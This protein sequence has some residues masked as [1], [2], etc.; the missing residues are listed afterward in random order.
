MSLAYGLDITYK[1]ANCV[2][3]SQRESWKDGLSAKGQT[4]HPGHPDY[5]FPQGSGVDV[6]RKNCPQAYSIDGITH[7]SSYN[8]WQETA[9]VEG[10]RIRCDPGTVLI[11][12]GCNAVTGTASINKIGP[13][14]CNDPETFCVSGSCT[15]TDA[16]RNSG[17]VGMGAYGWKGAGGNH[18]E[19]DRLWSQGGWKRF[20][21][22]LRSVR[23]D[24]R[25][26]T[27]NPN[28][29]GWEQYKKLCGLEQWRCRG[30][31][32]GE[33]VAVCTST[34]GFQKLEHWVP[35]RMF[36]G[37]DKF[38]CRPGWKVT[39]GGTATGS[40]YHW[41]PDEVSK[42]PN[43]PTYQWFR[44]NGLNAPSGHNYQICA[45]YELQ[46]TLV[47]HFSDFFSAVLSVVLSSF[48][49]LYN[50]F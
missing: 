17:T 48:N 22:A 34:P 11:G 40:G 19:Y 21:G 28:W 12:G 8:Q 30:G 31:E 1:I 42:D 3:P 41:W 16:Q 33:A 36:M 35:S 32:G 39:S 44:N 38:Q 6:A 2:K 9:D 50:R 47:Y 29:E 25:Y 14:G 37:T 5:L 24:K 10:P 7:S 18:E 27:N 23:F 46:C 45:N 15:P 43:G 13:E 4:S 20:I 26:G 49:I